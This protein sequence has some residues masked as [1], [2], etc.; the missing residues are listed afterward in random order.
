M[1][2][3]P[4][5]RRAFAVGLALGAL[6]SCSPEP[7]ATSALIVDYT[8]DPRWTGM[9]LHLDTTVLVLDTAAV[10]REATTRA[11]RELDGRV[12]DS[13]RVLTP[14]SA[15]RVYGSRAHRGAIRVWVQAP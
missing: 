5:A 3:H 8:F 10:G 13:M 1:F 12:I 2:G 7:D 14:D 11:L 15:L 6:S 9:V 4:R